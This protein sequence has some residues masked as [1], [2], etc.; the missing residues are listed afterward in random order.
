MPLCLPAPVAGPLPAPWRST[1][2][3]A[4]TPPLLQAGPPLPGH[5][6]QLKCAEGLLSLAAKV[7]LARRDRFPSAPACCF[8]LRP[9][10]RLYHPCVNA[11]SF[12]QRPRVLI[13]A[14]FSVPA[15]LSISCKYR[16]PTQQQARVKG[17]GAPR[18]RRASDRQMKGGG[19]WVARRRP[20]SGCAERACFCSLRGG[21]RGI[22]RGR[23]VR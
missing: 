10:R 2:H 4:G 20:D 13:P 8:A 21:T 9:R 16:P 19:A 6:R 7:T 1:L 15:C 22:I 23:I 18:R 3:A 12:D 11:L 5:R 14:C 17:K